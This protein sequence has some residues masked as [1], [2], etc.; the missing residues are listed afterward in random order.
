MKPSTQGTS[1]QA[2]AAGS[3]SLVTISIA[4]AIEMSSWGT[5][6]ISAT[7]SA[8]FWAEAST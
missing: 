1:A 7:C 6:S 8:R 4:I 2:D 5:V 3:L